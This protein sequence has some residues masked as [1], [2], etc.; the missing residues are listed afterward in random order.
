[1][2]AASCDDF[3]FLKNLESAYKVVLK[4]LVMIVDITNLVFSKH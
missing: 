1:M 2:E 4:Q 3:D